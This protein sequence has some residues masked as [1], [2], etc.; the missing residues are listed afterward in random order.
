MSFYLL[1]FWWQVYRTFFLE[2]HGKMGLTFSN[3]FLHVL[4]PFVAV[5]WRFSVDSDVNI[6]KLVYD[7]FCFVNVVFD[8]QTTT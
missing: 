2:L 5:S 1:W 4:V 3:C 8:I 6:E 7:V